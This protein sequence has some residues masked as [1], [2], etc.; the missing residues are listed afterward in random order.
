MRWRENRFY[1]PNMVPV[2]PSFSDERPG[3]AISNMC[4]LFPLAEE[5]TEVSTLIG[6][7][8]ALMVQGL[9]GP[10]VVRTFV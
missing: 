10:E 8:E 6:A 1:L 2:L 4:W 9:T 7:I 5:A 3:S